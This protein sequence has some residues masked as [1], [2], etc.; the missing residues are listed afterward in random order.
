MADR[1]DDGPEKERPG[2]IE[3]ILFARV[4]LWIILLLLFLG[5][6]I[7]IGF[8]AAVR[9]AE[10]GQFRLGP[11]SRAALAVAK[12]PETAK[13]MLMRDSALVALNSDAY[14]SKPTGW[15]FPSGALTAPDGYIL[16]SRYDGTAKRNKLE[17]V[18]LPGMQ[19]VHSWTLDANS[20]LKDVTHVSRFSDHANWDRAHFRQVHP[21]LTEN[22]DLIVKDHYSPLVRVD[23]CGK[24]LWTLQ[25]VV[26][27][28]STEADAEGNLWIPS[29]AE[30]QTI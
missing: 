11:V 27:H 12:I 15:N 9:E 18:S 6:F 1:G 28:H 7:V 20:L 3:R 5:C 30:Q 19:T 21:W 29:T 17:L 4:E 26:Y 22:G 2:A 24:V 8:G 14:K 13:R 23:P 10:R 16:M 25:D